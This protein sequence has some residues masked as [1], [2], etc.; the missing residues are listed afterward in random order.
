VNLRRADDLA[1]LGNKFGMVFLPLPVGEPDAI[2]RLRATKR[3]MD[4]IKKSP[5]AVL[6]FGILRALGRT[7]T[8]ALIA[9]VNLLGRKATAVMT[10]VPGPRERICFQ[11]V[12]IDDIMFWVPQSGRLGLGVS[13]LSYA[14]QVRIGVAADARL[15]P[16]PEA[17]VR[18]FHHALDELLARAPASLGGH[19]PPSAAEPVAA[20][21]AIAEH[22]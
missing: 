11:G 15:I 1:T 4:R 5:E 16:D 2:E 10:N 19:A 22:P 9:A 21:R 18:A 8:A 12:P 14:G 17:I 6:I 20:A 7:T 3:A 13:I